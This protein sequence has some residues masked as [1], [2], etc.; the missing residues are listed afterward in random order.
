LITGLFS[1][2]GIAISGNNLFVAST[3]GA[4]GEYTT[5][6]ATV[7]ALLIRFLNY[8]IGL[9]VS[10]NDLFV[11]DESAGVIGEYTTSGA[12]VNASLISG[13]NGNPLGIAVVPE[14]ETLLL[15]CFGGLI[16]FCRARL[17]RPERGQN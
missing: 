4:I 14:P 5:S 15:L 17:L 8:P 1:P 11:A 9:A 12:T 16:A 6:G 10:G 7:N 13:G 3:F 2:S